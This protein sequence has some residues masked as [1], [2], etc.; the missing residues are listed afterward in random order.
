M[1]RSLGMTVTGRQTAQANSSVGAAFC[2]AAV[3]EWGAASASLPA[4]FTSSG[5][6][7]S[8]RYLF[9]F[10]KAIVNLSGGARCQ[11]I[12]GSTVNSRESGL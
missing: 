10:G 11:V 9:D 5:D 2:P 12:V 7:D 6:S 8:D 4:M 1:R 3:Q